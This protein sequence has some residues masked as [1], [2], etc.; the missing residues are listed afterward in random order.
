MM[1]K[2]TLL[3]PVPVAGLSAGRVFR[4]ALGTCMLSFLL[5]S[6]GFAQS[7]VD[8]CTT[9]YNNNAPARHTCPLYDVSVTT[10]G[11]CFFRATCSGG[12][13]SSPNTST[14]IA[15]GQVS[16]LKNC[17]GRFSTASSCSVY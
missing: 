4:Y 8:S 2:T 6:A 1:I 15:E 14:S 9:A 12:S 10:S 17:N 7:T 13:S 16:S 3:K 11:N 5:V